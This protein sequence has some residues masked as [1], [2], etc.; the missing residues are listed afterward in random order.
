M[1]YKNRFLIVIY[2]N[3][4]LSITK[5]QKVIISIYQPKLIKNTSSPDQTLYRA[6]TWNH[7][8]THGI[9]ISKQSII[10][11]QAVRKI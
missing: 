8:L 6:L 5:A 3:C 4:M 7:Y 10:S 9:G 1:L 2:W 11:S